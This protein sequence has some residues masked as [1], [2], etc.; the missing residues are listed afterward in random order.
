MKIKKRDK[1]KAAFK[2]RYR[3]FEYLV[4]PFSLTNVLATF[5]KYVN[6]VLRDELDQDEVTYVN[7]IQVTG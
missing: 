5:R 6:W 4:M 3:T 1:W 7:S 2:T